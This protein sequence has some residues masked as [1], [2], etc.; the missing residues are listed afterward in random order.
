MN[1]GS[2]LYT[3]SVFKCVQLISVSIFKFCDISLVFKFFESTV[4]N[5]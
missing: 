3:G 1:V 4:L 2:L 5:A